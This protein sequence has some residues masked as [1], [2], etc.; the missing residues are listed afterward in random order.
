M[1]GREPVAGEGLTRQG[2]TVMAGTIVVTTF[3]DVRK[4]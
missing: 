4:D 3:A 2:V 1:A